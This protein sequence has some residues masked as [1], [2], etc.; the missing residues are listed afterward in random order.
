MKKTFTALPG[1]R[2]AVEGQ[3]RAFDPG[4]RAAM[5]F[6]HA[7]FGAGRDHSQ[8]VAEPRRQ[9][10]LLVDVTAYAATRRRIKLAHIDDLQ[11]RTPG[12]SR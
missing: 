11:E 4:D 6:F 10:E 12:S 5:G 1:Q 2:V 9:F 8:L 7:G 3:V